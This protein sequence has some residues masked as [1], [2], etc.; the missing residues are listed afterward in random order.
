MD[1]GSHMGSSFVLASLFRSTHVGKGRSLNRT[2]LQT[3][4]PNAPSGARSNARYREVYIIPRFPNKG[5]GFS[6]SELKLL[7]AST[8]TI[9]ANTV[10]LREAISTYAFVVILQ[11]ST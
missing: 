1:P 7:P 6:V 3:L 9:G 10:H 2:R 5:I 11:E 4:A 8:Y